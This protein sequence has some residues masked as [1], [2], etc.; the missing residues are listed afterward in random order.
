MSVTK[1]QLVNSIYQ[2][3]LV[4]TV[5][6]VTQSVV[7]DISEGYETVFTQSLISAINDLGTNGISLIFETAKVLGSTTQNQNTSV[8]TFGDGTV[9]ISYPSATQISIDFT[10][11]AGNTINWKM[12]II[13]NSITN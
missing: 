4:Q 1:V 5:G 12:L 7:I 11:V 6:A 10:G 13:V 8:N 9:G 3:Y 2:T